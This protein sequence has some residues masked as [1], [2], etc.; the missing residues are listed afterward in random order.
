M[1][2]TLNLPEKLKKLEE[3]AYNLWFSW[4]PD[5]RDLFRDINRAMWRTK[6][7]NPVAVLQSASAE[8][9]EELANDTNYVKKLEH[10]Y[11]RFSRYM[12]SGNTLFNQNYPNLTGQLVAYFSA[13]YGIHESLPNYA[14]GLG[15][16]AGDHCK[17]ASDLGLPFVA[18]G[19]MYKHA[20]F[21]QYINEKGEQIEEYKE[22]NLDELPIRLVK[23]DNDK[24][25]LVSVPI[26]DREVFIKIW[27]V[28]VGRINL[29]LLDTN[30]ESN[31]EE[32]KNII[33]S[34]YGGSRDTRIQQEIILGI[35][36][37][38][39][40]RKMGLNPTMFHMNEG[41]SAFLGLE[42]LYELINDGMDFKPALQFVRSTT[43]FTTHTPIPA[44]NEAFEFEM[45]ER[46]FKDFWPQLDM[47]DDYFFDLGRNV[48]IHQHENF[49]LTILALNLSY[50]ANGVSKLH[51]QVSRRMWQK[52]FP[53]IPTEE[54]PIGHVTNGIHT[55]SWL[56]REMIAMFNKYM[57]PDWREYIQEE[58]FWLKIFEV[59]DEEF[60]NSMQKMKKDMT[61]RLRRR[62]TAQLERYQG[63]H[64][65]PGPDEILDE[66]TLTIGFA[67]RF[68]PYKRA[69]LIFRDRERIKKILNH[70]DKPL[71][72][73]FSGKAHPQNDA[74]KELI[75]EINAIAREDGLRG[76]IVFI[77]NYSINTSRPLVSGVDVWLN[78]PRRPLEASGTSGQKVPINGGINFSVLDGWWPEG[79]NG[80]N[81]WTIGREVEYSNHLQQDY[82]DS[83]QMY[84]TL[85]KEIIPLFYKR[86]K[87]GIPREW[88]KMAKESL[89]S[90]IT[91]FST[92]TMLWNYITKYY[93][94]GMYRNIKYTEK[95]NA[96]LFRFTRWMNRINRHWRKVH[97]S[98]NGA[99]LGE[100]NRIFGPGETKE[101]SVYV[102][103]GA[104]KAEELR[105]ELILERQDA[106]KG[107]Q[108]METY[109]MGLIGQVDDNTYE[110]RA[111]VKAKQDGTY[112]FNC[113]VIPT[114]PDMFNKH[115]SRLIRWLD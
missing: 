107:H 18:V 41:H 97:I 60:W 113:R 47:S 88:V 20:Y 32:D 12:A 76:K 81:G 40:L 30:V 85:E 28:A 98:L 84:E 11:T 72:I 115:E 74:G 17:T 90:T 25:V 86:D 114:H 7:R 52:V 75:R 43:L 87:N 27:R 38:R 22:L 65:F 2:P 102:T 73:L 29:Y 5:A 112:R 100:D 46:Y 110:Y 59:P 96:G 44:G 79:Y 6:T 108:H 109:P 31:T 58:D 62:Y 92:H 54:V 61:D 111:R 105:V 21:D 78:N 1:A 80:K 106:I 50:M 68:A 63:D 91:K 39:A 14:G 42:R 48:N 93:V 8:R 36:G 10:V 16:L 83:E 70:A 64:G 24:P 67:R 94:P 66:H 13:E 57:G 23:D 55:E 45:M 37:I 4:N 15:V 53:A 89:R 95:E 104:L 26:L 103:H 35:G 33:H 69:T 34:L 9:L 77:E 82:E 19:L 56:H 3:L 71:Q 101:I 49:S 99:G 51:A